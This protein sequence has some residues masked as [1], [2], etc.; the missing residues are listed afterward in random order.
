MDNENLIEINCIK[1]ISEFEQFTKQIE[2]L[3]KNSSYLEFKHKNKN[4]EIFNGE[5]HSFVKIILYLI[6]IIISLIG[7]L[8]IILVISCNKNMRKRGNYFIL[9]LAVCDLA[10]LFSCMWIQP[11]LILYDNLWLFGE[12]FCKINSFLQMISIIAFVITLSLISCDR[13]IGIVHPLKSK[14]ISSKISYFL[15]IVVWTISIIIS[16]PIFMYRKYAER[17]WSD[18]IEKICDDFGWSVSFVK[19]ENGCFSKTITPLK[20]IYHTTVII[21]IFFLPMI[22]MT[23]AYSIMIKKLWPKENRPIAEK[24]SLYRTKLDPLINKR[25]KKATLMLLFLMFIFF[26]CWYV[27]SFIN[28]FHYKTKLFF[29]I[30]NLNFIYSRAP[31]EII[32]LMIEYNDEVYKFCLFL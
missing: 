28:N 24:R 26:I 30:L 2:D 13:Y 11:I 25:K 12:L 32:L 29:I 7:N 18:Y 17:K 1:N 5:M 20:R 31:L 23:I 10:I 9:N 8:M 22:V 16:I 6:V 4:N 3:R 21:I 27:I 14:I 15:I 19:D